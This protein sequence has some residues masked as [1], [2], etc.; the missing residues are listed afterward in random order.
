MISTFDP[1]SEV[2]LRTFQVPNRDDLAGKKLCTVGPT[3]GVA[4]RLSHE[5]I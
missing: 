1:A 4:R 3:I 5:I 2:G